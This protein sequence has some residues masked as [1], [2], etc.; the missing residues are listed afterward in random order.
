MKYVHDSILYDVTERAA[1]WVTVDGLAPQTLVGLF[2]SWIAND[3]IQQERM[4]E[5]PHAAPV[6]CFDRH[7]CARATC[8]LLSNCHA[9]TDPHVKLAYNTALCAEMGDLH[10]CSAVQCRRVVVTAYGVRSCGVTQQALGPVAE[11][12]PES[13]YR[14]LGIVWE[15]KGDLDPSARSETTRRTQLTSTVSHRRAKAVFRRWLRREGCTST[16]LGREFALSL[17][18]LAWTYPTEHISELVRLAADDN[19]WPGGTFAEASLVRKM[20]RNKAKANGL[21]LPPT[22]PRVPRKR[23]RRSTNNN[24]APVNHNGRVVTHKPARATQH[25][26]IGLSPS[27]QH[28]DAIG[29]CSVRVAMSSSI[30]ISASPAAECANSRLLVASA[31]VVP[32]TTTY[33]PV[34]TTAARAD[35]PCLSPTTSTVR[36]TLCKRKLAVFA[37]PLHPSD[38]HSPG[39]LKKSKQAKTQTA[40]HPALVVETRSALRPVVCVDD[41]VLDEVKCQ[42]EA[43]EPAKNENKSSLCNDTATTLTQ[44]EQ[45]VSYAHQ[46][47][48][49]TDDH[50]N[51]PRLQYSPREQHLLGS[52]LSTLL[53]RDTGAPTYASTDRGALESTADNCASF[54]ADETSGINAHS[55]TNASVCT[56]AWLRWEEGIARRAFSKNPLPDVDVSPL[57]HVANPRPLAG[58]QTGEQLSHMSA[59]AQTACM[60]EALSLFP[61][62]FGCVY[63]TSDC[64]SRFFD[65]E[66]AYVSNLTARFNKIFTL[67]VASYQQLRYRARFVADVLP[68]VVSRST[69]I[70]EGDYRGTVGLR[71]CAQR[72]YVYLRAS[73][74]SRSTVLSGASRAQTKGKNTPGVP[75]REGQQPMSRAAVYPQITVYHTC[76]PPPVEPSV[77][78]V[79]DQHTHGPVPVKGTDWSLGVTSL[80]SPVP[81]EP[82][83]RPF[84]KLT[85]TVCPPG[86]RQQD[87]VPTQ[88]PLYYAYTDQWVP[89]LVPQCTLALDLAADT[90]LPGAESYDKTLLLSAQRDQLRALRRLRRKSTRRPAMVNKLYGHALVREQLAEGD[91]LTIEAI[92]YDTL[93]PLYFHMV[94]VHDNLAMRGLCTQCCRIWQLFVSKS[95]IMVDHMRYT[96]DLHCLVVLYSAMTGKLAPNSQQLLFPF[97]PTLAATLP[98]GQ[99]LLHFG[100]DPDTIEGAFEFFDARLRELDL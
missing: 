14:N 39:F 22:L 96:F 12:D 95:T 71:T 70:A 5:T 84:T 76:T 8:T 24:V 56:R 47:T 62:Q 34:Y 43:R 67:L 57:R 73:L 19:T 85:A 32:A 89:S 31:C 75:I 25:V 48:V 37:H 49:R 98:W 52:R 42:R 88:E 93:R 61:S 63:N 54:E 29:V 41:N 13:V 58:F 15:N 10:V 87:V 3:A 30:S 11:T 50:M 68:L 2:E 17:R 80:M 90:G 16:D 40:T 46:R 35:T 4:S 86:S 44:D 66:R 28:A 79:S 77:V 20:L 27:K 9:R 6:A 1:E 51:A 91:P 74:G 36:H 59:A 82:I 72:R 94:P 23:K 92:S 81:P 65:P 100:Y 78:P 83:C 55:V 69:C 53:T 45:R 64:I 21:P 97:V 38:E 18:G 7:L 99:H 26:S 33:S 60:T